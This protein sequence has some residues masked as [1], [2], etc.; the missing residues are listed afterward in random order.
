MKKFLAL[1][2]AVVMVFA[3]SVT[4]FAAPADDQYVTTKAGTG[5]G[6]P[7][8]YKYAD[9]ADAAANAET[10]LN[11]VVTYEDAPETDRKTDDFKYITVEGADASVVGH[12]YIPDDARETTNEQLDKTGVDSVVNEANETGEVKEADSVVRLT[13][14]P[15]QM[16]VTVPTVLPVSVDKGGNVYVA[17]NAEITNLSYAPVVVKSAKVYSK[18]APKLVAGT[19]AGGKW[20][21]VADGTDFSKEVVGAKKY[22]FALNSQYAA[23]ADGAIAINVKAANTMANDTSEAAST[24]DA[25]ING[26]TADDSS[27]VR[28]FTYGGE[29]TA[30]RDLLDS[31]EIAGVTF[32]ID[33]APAPITPATGD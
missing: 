26:A 13:I 5:E 24:L 11:A 33:W 15:T 10:D 19:D 17:T 21:L 7:R 6:A 14:E 20:T 8:E 25:Q 27:N 28:A 2:L 29:F 4:A 32:T 22:T 18:D 16:T 1:L 3:M 30:E 12:D 9:A 31:A 23:A